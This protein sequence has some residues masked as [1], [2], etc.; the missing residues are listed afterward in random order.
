MGHRYLRQK[1]GTDGSRGAFGRRN[2]KAAG[3]GTASE[4][5][6]GFPAPCI[7]A[8]PG[9]MRASPSHRRRA[10]SWPCCWCTSANWLWSTPS[11][12]NSGG[13]AAGDRVADP[14]VLNRRKTLCTLTGRSLADAARVEDRS[15]TTISRT[16]TR[17]VG[18]GSPTSSRP[19]H[20]PARR[21]RVPRPA[22]V[23]ASPFGLRPSAF[24]LR[25]SRSGRQ[26]PSELR[27]CRLQAQR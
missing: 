3:R 16:D 26:A 13:A 10:R 19:P 1:R 4:F 9:R 25:A 2:P 11:C 7:R 18:T 27:L 17:V 8:P 22:A 6:A 23:P 21:C 15:R 12:G 5:R 14:A 24:A 20:A